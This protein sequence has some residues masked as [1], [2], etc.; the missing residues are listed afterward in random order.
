MAN[1]NM[2]EGMVAHAVWSS[3]TD[4]VRPN[5]V[6]ATERNRRRTAAWLPVLPLVLAII[7]YAFHQPFGNWS[8]VL[9]AATALGSAVVMRPGRAGF[10]EVR[11]DGSLG[12]RLGRSAPELSG[13]RRSRVSTRR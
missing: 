5:V 7:G 8:V 11:E 12:T 3:A 13:M 10:Y 6:Y 4:V 9:L 2:P 1:L